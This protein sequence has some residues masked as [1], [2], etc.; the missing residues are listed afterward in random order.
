MLLA[1]GA[2]V[3][4]VAPPL[5]MRTWT[6]MKPSSANVCDPS[7]PKTWAPPG[8]T[9]P[10]ETIVPCEFGLPSFQRIVAV[11]SEGGPG[12][13]LAS[14]KVATRVEVNGLPSTIGV[15]ATLL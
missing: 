5:L 14:V 2:A 1:I 7:T 9:L 8:P 6:A 15:L 11:Y 10:S 4:A 3:W 13:G 12:L